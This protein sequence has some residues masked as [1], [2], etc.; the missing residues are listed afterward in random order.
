MR[1]VVVSII[2]LVLTVQAQGQ[3]VKGNCYNGQGK[4]LISN[5]SYYEGDFSASK[6]HGKGRLVYKNGDVYIGSFVKGQ[7]ERLGKYIFA[8]NSFYIGDFYNDQRHGKGKMIFANKEVYKGTWINGVMQGSGKYQFKNGARYEGEFLNGNLHGNG[9]M[10]ES[11][12]R[13][14]TGVWENNALINPNNTNSQPTSSKPYKDCTN[15]F[16]DNEKGAYYY[17]DGSIYFGHF[18]KGNPDG[19]GRCEYIN[20]D[21]YVGGW[22]NH[23]PHGNGIMH[24]KNGEKLA[25]EFAYGALIKRTYT[26]ITS[27]APP[28]KQV[29]TKSK[30]NEGS[31]IYAVIVGVA[32]YNHMQSLKYTDDD[33]YQL[34]AFLKSP[35][36]GAIPDDQISV[37]IDDGAT[38]KTIQSEIERVFS[39]ADEDD[40]VLLYLSGHGLNGAY[41]PY[42]FDGMNNLLA[43][44]TIINTIN[45]T[46]AKNKIF[47][48]DACHSGSMIASRD[49]MS[50]SLSNY[51]D[52]I[53]EDKGGIAMMTSSKSSEVS[54]EYSGMRQGVF[55]HFL[56]RGLKGEAN[57]NNDAIIS[58]SELYNYISQNVKHYTNSAQ[59]PSIAGNYSPDMPVA[60]V[61]DN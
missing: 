32:T 14:V 25:G 35:K 26:D 39:K 9:T 1:G 33:A 12:G 4:Y 29:S 61:F 3:C 2:V 42:D 48:T 11:N 15:A 10:I 20:G 60:M 37:L 31:K 17:S 34:Y 41:V 28:K 45:N 8:D 50:T 51:Y 44:S 43:Y 36:G 46:R 24:L 18:I 55:S 6:F 49:L 57:K 13:S 54:L 56:I 52:L 19:E 16:C 27:S 38:T 22:K 47:I 5:T 53:N 7:K 30:F 40:V 59:N 21:L 23:S 58:I